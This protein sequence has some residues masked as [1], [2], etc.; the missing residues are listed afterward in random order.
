MHSLDTYAASKLSEIYRLSSIISCQSSRVVR[1]T[2]RVV[3][4]NLRVTLTTLRV[5]LTDLRVT[6]MTLSFSQLA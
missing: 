3:R 6:H 1:F 4:F 2:L 5:N